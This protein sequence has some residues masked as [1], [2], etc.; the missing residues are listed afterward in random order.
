MGSSSPSKEENNFR[1]YNH[2]ESFNNPVRQQNNNNFNNGIEIGYPRQNSGPIPKFQRDNN[3][4]VGNI[5]IDFEKNHKCQYKINELQNLLSNFIQSKVEHHY[6]YAQNDGENLDKN[7][8]Y[9]LLRKFEE[10]KLIGI[11]DS[12]KREIFNEIKSKLATISPEY[13]YISLINKIFN[14]QNGK[15]VYYEKFMKQIENINNNHQSPFEIDYLTIM[16]VGKSGVGKSTLINS[17]LKLQRGERA[18]TGTGN[19][20]TENIRIYE[21]QALPYMKLVDTRGIELSSGFGAKE[22]ESM[23]K[24]YITQ[25]Y[26]SNNPNKFVHCIW[27]CIT[28]NRFEQ[29]E[30]DFLNALRNSYADNSIPIL[31]VYTQAT[32]KNTI[33]EMQKYIKDKKINAYFIQVLAERKELVNGNFMEAFGLSELVSRTLDKTRNALKGEMR[34]VMTNNIAKTIS[35]SLQKENAYID[36]FSFENVIIKFIQQ[37]NNINDDNNCIEFILSLFCIYIENFFG[38]CNYESISKILR[39]EDL[40]KNTALRYLNAIRNCLDNKITPLLRDKS[41]EFINYQVQIQKNANRAIDIQKQRTIEEFNETSRKFIYDYYMYIAQVNLISCIITMICPKFSN[42]LAKTAERY[43][44]DISRK[45]DIQESVSQCF[46]N[47]F[48]VYEKKLSAF[49]DV[50]KGNIDSSNNDVN[51]NLNNNFQENN[52]NNFNNNNNNNN[53]NNYISLNSGDNNFTNQFQVNFNNNMFYKPSGEQDDELPDESE[54]NQNNQ[55]NNNNYNNAN[56][57]NNFYPNFKS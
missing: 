25:Q 10:E 6:S 42:C 46:L 32:D 8:S 37:Y 29:V 22:I 48:S 1:Q 15:K 11:I 57:G 24:G 3:I 5:E 14:S 39:G 55:F 26:K 43:I 9:Y 16:L 23:A 47:K 49:M 50:N 28:G 7:D 21:S 20:V 44:S 18:K 27:Y 19:F 51:I 54:L 45:S 52:E 12:K 41:I 31:V 35:R 56:I 38:S 34:S 36:L 17:L 53:N 13:D 2:L 30:I 4:G 40:I 33:A